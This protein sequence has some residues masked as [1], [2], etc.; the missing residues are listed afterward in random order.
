MTVEERRNQLAHAR[1]YGIVDF[2]YVAEID[3]ARVTA[4]LLDG[5]ADVIQLRAKGVA[6]EAVRK[7]GEI[8]LPLCKD[9]KIPFV[10]ND[11]PEMAVELGADGVHIGQDDGAIGDVRKLVGNEMLIGRSTHSFSQAKQA[12]A[13]DADYIGFGPLYPTPTKQGRPAIGLE[14]VS[15][16]EAEV[17]MHLPAFCIGGIKPKNLGEVLAAGGRRCVVVSHLLQAEDIEGAT[18]EVRTAMPI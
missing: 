13:N 15:R 16:M 8:I 1:L 7:A 3:V 11:Y 18:R 2:G 17:G 4:A 9:A 14:E 6:L 5:G 10:L 12:L